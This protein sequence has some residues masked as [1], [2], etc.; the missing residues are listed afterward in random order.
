M[1]KK[2]KLKILI[3]FIEDYTDENFTNKINIDSDLKSFDFWDSIFKVQLIVFLEN[4]LSQNLNEN[5][6]NKI[7]IV[8]N[9]SIEY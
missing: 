1:K 6:I 7:N 4:K 3:S 2:I 9:I 5:N 8:K